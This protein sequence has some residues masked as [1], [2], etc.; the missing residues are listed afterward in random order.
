MRHAPVAPYAPK[1]L[2]HNW[3]GL[4]HTA[5]MENQVF[6]DSYDKQSDLISKSN[7]RKYILNSN[8]IGLENQFGAKLDFDYQHFGKVTSCRPKKKLHCRQAKHTIEDIL[9]IKHKPE[10]KR[11]VVSDM[12][13]DSDNESLYGKSTSPDYKSGQFV[14]TYLFLISSGSSGH[15]CCWF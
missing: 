4:G 9:G 15:A 14:H 12:G 13:D 11:K 6:F 7:L 10:R 5:S 1:P 8:L 3:P 2:C